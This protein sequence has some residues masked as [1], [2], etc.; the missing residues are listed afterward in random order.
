VTPEP[1]ESDLKAIWKSQTVE[2]MT[3]SI[4]S[5]EELRS[6]ARKSRTR[7][8]RDLIARWIFAAAASIFCA[9]AVWSAR[10][11]A[12]RVIAGLVLAMLLIQAVRGLYSFVRGPAGIEPNDERSSFLD[13]YRRE[14]E[15]QQ[16]LARQPVWQ[17]AAA[18]LIIGWLMRSGMVRVNSMRPV[19]IITLIAAA[20]LVIMLS[21]KKFD[22][23]RIQK[24]IDALDQFEADQR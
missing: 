3:M 23:R 1:S 8:R 20:G 14:L 13:F 24:E 18:L 7:G 12:T 5:I 4:M 19:L 16:Q 21:M 10:S 17:A 6:R 11:V 22:A 9:F 2:N 15:R